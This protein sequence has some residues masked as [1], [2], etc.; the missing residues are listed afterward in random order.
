[1]SEEGAG[2]K[3][4]TGLVNYPASIGSLPSYQAQVEVSHTWVR[5]RGWAMGGGGEEEGAGIKSRTGLVNYLAS[6]GSLLS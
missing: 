5:G 1:M 3:S 4:R 6:I 2:I